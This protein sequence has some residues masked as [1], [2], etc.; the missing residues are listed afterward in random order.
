VLQP[1]IELVIVEDL[2]VMEFAILTKKTAVLVSRTAK[3][4]VIQEKAALIP[5]MMEQ[6]FIGVDAIKVKVLGIGHVCKILKKNVKPK[7]VIQK[8]DAQTF[9]VLL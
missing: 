6:K 2:V 7:A 5:V 9:I 4:N 1:R 8:W 3:V